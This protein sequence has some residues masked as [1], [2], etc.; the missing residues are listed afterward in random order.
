[1]G[2]QDTV[3]NLFK[4]TP[5]FKNW[6][7]QEDELERLYNFNPNYKVN[8]SFGEAKGA[9]MMNIWGLGPIPGGYSLF[10][11]ALGGIQ[12]ALAGGGNLIYQLLTEENK[13]NA[14]PAA[15]E[16]TKGYA[17]QRF[18]DNYG[19]SAKEIF[20]R[21]IA[22]EGI[23]NNTN[24][25]ALGGPRAKGNIFNQGT[26]EVEDYTTK[27]DRVLAE[28]ARIEQQ[29]LAKIAEQQRLAKIAEQQRL[30]KIAEQQRLAKIA[31]QQRLDKIAATEQERPI[32]GFGPYNSGD[33][34]MPAANALQSHNEARGHI[35]GQQA[36]G[37][38][39]AQNYW[40]HASPEV[41]PQN[42]GKTSMGTGKNYAMSYNP[43]TGR[44]GF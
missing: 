36:T 28:R 43:L 13:L 34:M 30:A 27:Q 5:V 12:T 37:E 18:D 10:N 26:M 19:R 7:E 22:L 35:I 25:T 44:G 6:R 42:K 39:A 40:K 15:W 1:M 2:Y 33:G 32:G 20:D 38:Q 14:I 8:P 16:Q 3:Y 24:I 23:N 4:D 31:E 41:N 9:N 29:R 17:Q 21:A 11:D